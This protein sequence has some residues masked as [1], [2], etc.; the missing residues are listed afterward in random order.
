M[1]GWYQG[2]TVPPLHNLK[3]HHVLNSF[4]QSR[5]PGLLWREGKVGWP[6]L[7]KR[8]VISQN[9]RLSRTSRSLDLNH[10]FFFYLK[11]LRHAFLAIVF[12]LSFKRQCNSTGDMLSYN[13]QDTKQNLP[14]YTWKVLCIDVTCLLPA[15]IWVWELALCLWDRNFSYILDKW[16]PEPHLEHL[17]GDNKQQLESCSLSELSCGHRRKPSKTYRKIRTT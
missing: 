7:Y 2:L 6:V 1:H 8:I 11:H 15:Y 5:S 12:S 17:L 14:S 4:L 9:H 13:S 3:T 16:Y 10:L